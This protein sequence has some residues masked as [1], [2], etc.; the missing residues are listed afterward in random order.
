MK[1]LLYSVIL[2][3]SALIAL[4]T[5]LMVDRPFNTSD[6]RNAYFAG[7]NI[8]SRRIMTFKSILTCEEIADL[9]KETL[10]KVMEQ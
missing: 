10:E 4:L 1:L 6:M 2:I 8:A 9:Y 7:C 3:L 5:N